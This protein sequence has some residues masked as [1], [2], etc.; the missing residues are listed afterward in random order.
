MT[1]TEETRD[2]WSA[3]QYLK[4]R[5]QRTHAA[6]DLVGQLPLFS[7]ARVVDL[8]CGPGNSTAVLASRFPDADIS[9]VDSSPDMLDRAR[10]TLPRIHFVQADLRTYE[11]DAEPCVDLLFSNAAFHW[12]RRGER[13]HTIIRLLK[14]QKPGCVFAFQMPD[15]HNEP[16]HR[17]MRDTARA[18]GPWREYFQKL[19]VQ[20][21]P[22]L[23]P[24]ESPSEYYNALI[25]Y[26]DKV[27][28]WHTYYQHVMEGPRDIVEWVKGSGLQPF[29][30]V[31]PNAVL[32]DDFLQ[33]YEMRLEA[34]YPRLADGK[35]MLRYPRIFVIALRK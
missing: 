21:R 4:F 23:D 34:A 14:T 30:N 10:R 24:I 19:D 31:L 5:N 27:D 20:D 13:L 17:A 11:P 15:Y 1:L 12:M 16:S 18:E 35:I 8:G 7:P 33:A 6:F 28:V 25:P 32:R 3:S 9:G 22:E 26:C 2:E 29:L